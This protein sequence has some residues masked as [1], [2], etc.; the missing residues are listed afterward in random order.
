MTTLCRVCEKRP[1][2]AGSLA[3]LCRPCLSDETHDADPELVFEEL[4]NGRLQRD[5]YHPR[6]DGRYNRVRKVLTKG[7]DFRYVG[8]DVVDKY[9][10]ARPE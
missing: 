6:E 7:G 10:I 2:V 4:E 3:T 5:E 9:K 1:T 8:T